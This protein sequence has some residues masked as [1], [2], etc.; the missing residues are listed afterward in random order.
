[1][2]GLR[3]RAAGTVKSGSPGVSTAPTEAAPVTTPS[4]GILPCIPKKPNDA[5]PPVSPLRIHK[6]RLARR[7]LPPWRCFS[8][9]PPPSIT[10]VRSSVLR[11]LLHGLLPY[12]LL[13]FRYVSESSHFRAGA[14]LRGLSPFQA[15]ETV[16]LCVCRSL[17]VIS[18][19]RPHAPCRFPPRAGA[20]GGS[21][22]RRG[23]P[24]QFWDPWSP[25][26]ELG[27]HFGNMASDVLV[28]AVAAFDPAR[29]RECLPFR[30]QQVGGTYRS[31]LLL[32]RAC[33]ITGG[34]ARWFPRSIPT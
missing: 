7:H 5:R 19:G 8:G 32:L 13:L 23:S 29:R 24:T 28:R 6:V 18:D 25:A 16:T 9:P 26:E 33:S 22:S 12:V 14:L 1:M 3:R 15:G 4:A 31:V 21:G 10:L 11:L 2:G 27:C 30:F 17:D 20:G 34:R